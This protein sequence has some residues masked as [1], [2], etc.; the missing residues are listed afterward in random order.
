MG[1][2]YQEADFTFHLAEE[3]GATEEEWEFLLYLNRS[4]T[5][6]RMAVRPSERTSFWDEAPAIDMKLS[7]VPCPFCREPGA[8]AKKTPSRK[9]IVLSFC[10]PQVFWFLPTFLSF[11]FGDRGCEAPFSNLLL[12]PKR[13]LWFLKRENSGPKKKRGSP[14]VHLRLSKLPLF[15]LR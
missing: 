2:A 10:G 12:G 3:C 9:P 14:L 6:G 1:A 8:S 7:N 13:L 4:E 11:C 15:C 5:S